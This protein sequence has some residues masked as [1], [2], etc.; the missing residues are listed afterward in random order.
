MPMILPG[1]GANVLGSIQNSCAERE[2][3]HRKM[4]TNVSQ[5]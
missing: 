2:A 4:L 1:V 5:R 3:E